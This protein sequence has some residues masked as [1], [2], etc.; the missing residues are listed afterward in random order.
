M[1]CPQC[2]EE[3]RRGISDPSFGFCDE[4][5]KKYRWID[6][7][8][9]LVNEFEDDIPHRNKT[10]SQQQRIPSAVPKNM[11]ATSVSPKNKWVALLFCMFGGVFGLHRFYVGRFGGG[12]LYLLTAGLFGVGWIVDIFIILAGGFQDSN[13]LKLK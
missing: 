6:D 3:L 12:V 11:Y 5:I 13:G 7:K 2:G 8:T 10:T 4:C 1:K 9:D